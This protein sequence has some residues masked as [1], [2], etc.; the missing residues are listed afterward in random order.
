MAITY[1]KVG[2]NFQKPNEQD[3]DLFEA[4]Q[5]KILN[6]YL[7]IR[8]NYLK[9]C[10]SLLRIEEFDSSK[11][12]EN[13]KEKIV[14]VESH[15]IRYQDRVKTQTG[16]EVRIVKFNIKNQKE[17]LILIHFL[18]SY[19]FKSS[20][21][22]QK[23]MK[24]QQSSKCKQ[25]NSK[26]CHSYQLK[27]NQILHRNRF[28]DEQLDNNPKKMVKTIKKIKCSKMSSNQNIL[29]QQYYKRTT[30]KITQFNPQNNQERSNP[31][32]SLIQKISQSEKDQSKT[33]NFQNI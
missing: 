30:L 10:V 12:A 21:F 5:S 2:Y 25:S 13:A 6:F 17:Q 27:N 8:Y 1:F 28:S 24:K 19:R 15:Q 31:L 33:L 26:D 22:T 32:K 23:C 4:Y 16:E 20:N 11:Q 29:K 18:P 9:N 3:V 7:L 14:K